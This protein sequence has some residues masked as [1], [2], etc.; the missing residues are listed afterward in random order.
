MKSTV[1]RIFAPYACPR[2]DSVAVH[3]AQFGDFTYESSGTEITITGYTGSGGDVIIPETIAG[4][5]ITGIGDFALMDCA[6][7]ISI[8]IPDSVTSI[9][10][11]AFGGCSNLTSVGI[12]NGVTRVLRLRQAD[13]RDGP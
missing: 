10:T 12:P 4:L 1:L 9:G 6:S 3:A 11:H 2:R 13:Q 8:T 7:L 5:P